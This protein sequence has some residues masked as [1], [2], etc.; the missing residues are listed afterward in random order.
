MILA[1]S[2]P[3]LEIFWTI[4]VFFAFVVWLMILFNVLG[5]LFRRHDTSGAT[6][7]LWIIFIVVLPYLGTFAYLLTQH[8]GMVERA[9]KQQQAAKASFDHY[10]QSVAVKPDPTEKIAK[11]HDLLDRGAIN[12]AE[13]D[14]IKRQAL[15]DG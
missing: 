2:Y 15:A 4:L 13:F 7:V 5:D 3:A 8:N 1:D 11:A 9:Q 14:Q 10:V 12:Q 6:K